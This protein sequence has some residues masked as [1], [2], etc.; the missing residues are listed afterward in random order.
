MRHDVDPKQRV[1]DSR[2]GLPSPA[3]DLVAGDTGCSKA[4]RAH[5]SARVS[6]RHRR[7]RGRALFVALTF[8]ALHGLLS[9]FG[10]HVTRPHMPNCADSHLK[11]GQ[12]ATS[13]ASMFHSQSS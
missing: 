1:A 4:Y 2:R 6:T 13:S 12:Y 3:P 5:L 10:C 7:L 8:A 11:A 9:K